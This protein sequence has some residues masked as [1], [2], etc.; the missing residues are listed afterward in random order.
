MDSNATVNP[1]FAN[2]NRV[3]LWYCDGASF[4]GNKDAVDHTTGTPLYFRGRR[5][6]DAMLDVLMSDHGLNTATEVLVSGGSAGGL[7]AY[8]HADYV[9]TRMPKTVTKFKASPVSGF[10]LLHEDAAGT[11]LYPNE[12]EYVFKMQNST[13]GVNAKCIASLPE[14]EQWRCIF[15]NYSYAHV[16]SPIFPLNS[17]IDAWQMGN[18]WKG[19]AGCTRPG[20]G[21]CSAGQIKDLNGY[22]GDFVLDM[23]RT[24]TFRKPGNGAFV[25]SCYEHCGV[26]T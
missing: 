6:L 3:V 7:A 25:E 21:K 9:R 2:F 11:P 15:A 18:I 13:G 19:D 17:A 12:M 8:L 26:Q 22:M 24:K 16:E 20:F 5:I 4:T 14:A 23:Q 10:F 1:T